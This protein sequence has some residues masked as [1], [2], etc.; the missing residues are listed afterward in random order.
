[1]TVSKDQLGVLIMDNHNSHITLEDVELAKNHGLDL[2]TLLPHHS[3]KL[4]PLDVSVFGAFKKFYNSF[5]DEWH[6]SHPGKTLSLYYF[7]ELSNKAVVKSCTLENITSSFKRTEIFSFSSEI[8]KED[9]FL[10]STVIDQVQ[11]VYS[12]ETN[13]DSSVL[14]TNEAAV[15]S[16]TTPVSSTP[17]CSQKAVPKTFLIESIAPVPKARPQKIRR[18]K[19]V[20]LPSSH[21]HL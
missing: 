21:A 4:Q 12:G 10:S 17:G 9:E 5:C 1:M 11:N 3:H 13:T 6:P 2:L 14:D 7:A 16:T 19:R 15:Q 18:C 20:F 8:F